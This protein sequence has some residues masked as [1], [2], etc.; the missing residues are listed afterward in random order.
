M[1]RR[2]NIFLNRFKKIK[3]SQDFLKKECLNVIEKFFGKEIDIN[4]IN[5]Y[6]GVLYLKIANPSLR[7]EIFLKKKEI[8]RAIKEN[9]GPLA[10]SDIKF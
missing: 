6:E 8:L 5:I 4:Q 7:N 1:W 10:P 9:I 3:P 2:A